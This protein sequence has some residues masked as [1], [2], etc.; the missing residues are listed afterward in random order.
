MRAR[1]ATRSQVLRTHRNKST[2]LLLR[3]RL[4]SVLC[5]HSFWS[6]LPFV[7]VISLTKY[8]T[9]C[10]FYSLLWCD[11]LFMFVCSIILLGLFCFVFDYSCILLQ[12][13]IINAECVGDRCAA[14]L[15]K[16]LLILHTH[17]TKIRTYLYY[18]RTTPGF[19][20]YFSISVVVCVCSS[21]LWMLCEEGAP[22]VEM[23]YSIHL[24]I[25]LLMTLCCV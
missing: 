3:C 9:F 6:S 7:Y 5:F 18:L 22:A 10:L 15:H 2:M 17:F 25:L 1:L 24:Y 11:Y 4:F 19:T 16:R 21:V 12:T 8:Q 13:Q 14:S 23:D 20:F